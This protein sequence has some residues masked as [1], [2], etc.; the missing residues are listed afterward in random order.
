MVAQFFC[1]NRGAA[2]A[3]HN[4]TIIALHKY[5]PRRLGGDFKAE[6]SIKFRFSFE[7][8]NSKDVVV[9][10]DFAHGEYAENVR[11]GFGEYFKDTA[12]SSIEQIELLNESEQA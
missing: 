6:F 10:E 12:V 9:L 8:V 5:P 3:E 7:V 2:I 1:G 11:V 4:H